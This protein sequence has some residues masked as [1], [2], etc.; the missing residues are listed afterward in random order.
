MDYDSN[1]SLILLL[2]L[3][4][5]IVNSSVKRF[6]IARCERLIKPKAFTYNI[7]PLTMSLESAHH[8][9][10]VE[11][12]YANVLHPTEPDRLVLKT[13]EEYFRIMGFKEHLTG[14]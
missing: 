8:S 14:Q 13:L 6:I 10:L 2:Q 7:R 1:H 12:A 5:W 11:V 9:Y 4:K 3:P